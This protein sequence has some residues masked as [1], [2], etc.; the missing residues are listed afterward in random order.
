[1]FKISPPVQPFYDLNK[2]LA[3]KQ[4]K[5]TSYLKC[6]TDCVPVYMRKCR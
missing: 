4:Q 5:S 6:V 3:F 1:M 2:I